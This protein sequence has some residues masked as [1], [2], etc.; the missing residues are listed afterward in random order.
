MYLEITVNAI[1]DDTGIS[2]FP[3]LTAFRSSYVCYSYTIYM[4]GF[5]SEEYDDKNRQIYQISFI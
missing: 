3:R 2:L 5:L 4:S 1:L